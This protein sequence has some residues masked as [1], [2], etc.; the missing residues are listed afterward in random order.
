MR[1]F[2]FTRSLYKKGMIFK[3]IIAF[4]I[5]MTFT[6]TALAQSDTPQNLISLIKDISKGSSNNVSTKPF[7][8]AI[9]KLKKGK[10][11]SLTHI[12]TIAI[13]L[14]DPDLKSKLQK[15]GV[16]AILLAYKP[17]IAGAKMKIV[18][19]EQEAVMA[20]DPMNSFLAYRSINAIIQSR[21]KLLRKLSIVSKLFPKLE[22]EESSLL[23]TDSENYKDAFEKAR[24][25]TA[26]HRYQKGRE[27]LFKQGANKINYRN[28]YNRFEES[29]ILIKGYKDAD[30]LQSIS[31][32]KGTVRIKILPLRSA[33]SGSHNNLAISKVKKE[34]DVHIA[35]N[36]GSNPFFEV[37][38][39]IQKPDVT[40]Q[41]FIEGKVTQQTHEPKTYNESRTIKDKKGVDKEITAKIVKYEKQSWGFIN[42]DAI[43]K[44]GSGT[45]IKE[46]DLYGS[47][48]FTDIWARFSGNEKAVKKKRRWLINEKT[49]KPF[50]KE[51][52]M[53]ATA[54]KDFSDD[55]LSALFRYLKTII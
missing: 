40:V 16:N 32:N 45:L 48:S 36:N 17:S 6:D 46:I 20:E 18:R 19:L 27:L 2:T 10:G 43:I 37:G 7:K 8:A 28:S 54:A 22:L 49:E 4:A 15:K 42:A 51:S 50:P 38:W 34:M 52:T 53:I 14:A 1:N 55:A 41:L 39:D 5:I 33:G 30:S 11:D 12:A 44:D 21:I 26:E 13:G 9:R 29:L 31:K 35:S 3:T 23:K 25:E 47:F 24:Q